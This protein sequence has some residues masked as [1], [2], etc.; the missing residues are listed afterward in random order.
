M[1]DNEPHP[2]HTPITNS[3]PNML[4]NEPHPNHTPI[5]NSNLEPP[6]P[7]TLTNQPHTA[8]D[9]LVILAAKTTLS[10]AQKMYRPHL[11]PKTKKT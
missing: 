3:K 5:T 6:N 11:H 7:K 2:N 1:L 4:D 9:A 8:E 10:E